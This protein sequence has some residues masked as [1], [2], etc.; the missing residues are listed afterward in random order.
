[1][2]KRALIVLAALILL[3]V[4][5]P[6]L[7]AQDARAQDYPTRPITLIV[8]FPPGG[9]TTIM[10]RI[11]AERMSANL[12]QQI[13]VDNRGGA[14]GTIGTRAAARSAPDGYT[15]VLGYTGTLAIGPSLYPQA[16]Y[17]PRKDFAAIG[18]IGTAPSVLVVHP[19][20]QARSV[21]ELIK[22]AKEKGELQYGSPGVGTANHL[23]AALFAH[24][25]GIKLTHIPYKGSGPA[26]NDLVGG[27]IPMMFVPIPV[28][29]GSIAGGR[30]RGLAVSSIKRSALLP[31]LPTVAE[32][33][34]PGYDVA[35]R[36]G[37]AAP[38]GTPRPI[39]ERLNKELN[40]ALTSEDVKKRLTTEGAE[41]ISGTPEDY[42]ADIDREEAMWSAL[43]KQIGVRAE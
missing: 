23:S 4:S 28:A 34:L 13:V 7:R 3:A 43:V 42:A 33:G 15:L 22:L 25:A 41:A 10:A 16:G 14:G 1:M 17:D 27:H 18:L 2:H 39:I 6:D 40:L 36:Y 29:H 9:S 8:P 20:V 5:A 24:Q 30:V 26:M 38:A 19:L 37:L 35:L 21:D 31:E 12:G 32:T 11:V